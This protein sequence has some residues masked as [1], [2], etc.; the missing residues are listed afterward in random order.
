M[1][2]KILKNIFTLFNDYFK[3]NSGDSC[4]E[5]TRGNVTL[6][7]C[8]NRVLQIQPVS[9]KSYFR[10][11]NCFLLLVYTIHLS[12]ITN[13][14]DPP[15][16]RTIYMKHPL[17]DSRKQIVVSSQQLVNSRQQ[18]VDSRQQI[19]DSRQQIVDSRQQILNLNFKFQI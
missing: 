9:Y 6:T 1:Y 18:I 15:P 13:L 7:I 8:R 17:V 5:G 2:E 3:E 14:V 19:V 4:S 10:C 16:M 12:L 11:N